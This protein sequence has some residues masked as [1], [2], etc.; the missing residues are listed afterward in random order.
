[1]NDAIKTI[2]LWIV[3]VIIL[4]SVFNN[5]GQTANPDMRKLRYSSL[6]K[7][8]KQGSIKSVTISDQDVTGTFLNNDKKFVSY[9]P[10]PQD[11]ALFAE[12]DRQKCHGERQAA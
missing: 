12:L 9:L 1:M 5:F 7:E 11:A 10:M 6:I 8:V 3:I 4:I 2:L